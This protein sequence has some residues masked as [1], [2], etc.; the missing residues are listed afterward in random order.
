[1]FLAQV[2]RQQAAIRARAA[3]LQVAGFAV[4]CCEADAHGCTL[5]VVV[6][7]QTPA[8][9]P[10]SAN[11]DLPMPV[12]LEGLDGERALSA[13]LTLVDLGDRPDQVETVMAHSSHEAVG[14]DVGGGEMVRRQTVP[15]RERSMQRVEHGAVR[16]RGRGR[17]E[18]DGQQRM[19]V[20]AGLSHVDLAD[21]GGGALL[22]VV[23]VQFVGRSDHRQGGR[24]AAGLGPPQDSIVSVWS[25]SVSFGEVEFLQPDPA[26]DRDGRQVEQ[27][28]RRR[29]GVDRHEQPMPN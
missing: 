4:A 16:D 17:R 21:P 13:R 2:Q 9:V 29:P 18:V 24:V 20:V 15:S 1:M 8:A 23:D 3:R 7:T 25:A 19:G 14:V 6:G 26:R 22:G 5:E 10:S 27:P 11:S 12:A 28:T